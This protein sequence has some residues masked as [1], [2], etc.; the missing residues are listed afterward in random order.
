[1]CMCAWVGVRKWVCVSVHFFLVSLCAQLFYLL[2][3]FKSYSSR[4]DSPLWESGDFQII[5]MFNVVVIKVV[6]LR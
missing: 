6:V 3:V 5:F 4:L 2:F 1:M